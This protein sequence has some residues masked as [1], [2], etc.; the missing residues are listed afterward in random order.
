[1]KKTLSISICFMILTFSCKKEKGDDTK[2]DRVQSISHENLF[3][4]VFTYDNQQRLSR[5]DYDA[6]SSLRF[7]YNGSGLLMQQYNG[8]APDPDRKYDLTIVNGRAVSGRQ[9]LPG[10]KVNEYDYQYDNANKMSSATVV[11]KTAGDEKETHYYTFH[12]DANDDLAETRVLKRADNVKVD[13]VAYS[14]TY[15]TRRPFLNWAHFGFDH[16]GN[17]AFSVDNLGYGTYMPQ[18]Y[19]ID[20]RPRTHAWATLTAKNYTWNAGLSV[21]VQLGS[22]GTSN[23][24][25]ADYVYDDRNRLIKADGL[26]IAWK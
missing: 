10:N 24:S 1:M 8:N 22:A 3:S 15:Y 26:T 18:L 7:E 23:R 19:G 6:G 21:W 4:H 25:E 9:Y 13:S 14:Y 2:Q 17:A 20:I 12:Y 11:L 5:I 16:F